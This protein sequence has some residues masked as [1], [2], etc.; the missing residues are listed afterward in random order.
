MLKIRYAPI[1]LLLTDGFD[2]QATTT[3]AVTLRQAGLRV[4]LVGL[5]AGSSR[6][7]HG[8]AL[9]PDKTLEQIL[10]K[11]GPFSA[12]IFSG[13]AAYLTRLQNDPRVAI[14]LERCIEAGAVLVGVGL[15]R[16]ALPLFMFNKDQG[17]RNRPDLWL[18]SD[19]N[20][21]LEQTV[22]ALTR[23]LE[24]NHEG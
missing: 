14:L 23:R 22:A 17:D 16:E 21:P 10:A 18:I 13:R 20:H 1:I 5:R 3:L 9:M 8:L 19:P 12:L 11:P 24:N 4:I 2:E 15:N 6:G 7:M